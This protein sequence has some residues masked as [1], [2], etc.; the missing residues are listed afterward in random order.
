MG[1]DTN[2]LDAETKKDSVGLKYI[3]IRLETL[4]NASFVIESV[5][6]Q[7]TRATISIKK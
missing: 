7:G 3:K 2:I 1:F 6:K 4:A 5:V